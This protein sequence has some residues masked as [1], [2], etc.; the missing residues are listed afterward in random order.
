MRMKGVI[1]GNKDIN[2]SKAGPSTIPL[3]GFFIFKNERFHRIEAC[4]NSVC[5]NIRIQK[6]QVYGYPKTRFTLEYQKK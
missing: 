3:S 5:E 1:A 4:R 6:S 2:K